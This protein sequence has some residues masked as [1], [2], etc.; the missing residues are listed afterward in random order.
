M[1][2]TILTIVLAILIGFTFGFFFLKKFTPKTI[3][4]VSNIKSQVYAFQIGVYKNKDNATKNA[5]TNNSI[6][7]E[8]N[9][10]YRVY[11]A[12]LK[13]QT[14]IDNLKKYYDSIGLNYYLKAINVSYNTENIINNYELLLNN[15]DSSNYDMILSSML[16]EID[17][18]NL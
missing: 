17:S 8:D 3:T 11:I 10:L 14:L 4:E 18:S 12:L 5:T 7:V 9:N 2:K 1:K 15:C 6:V 13:D 16:K